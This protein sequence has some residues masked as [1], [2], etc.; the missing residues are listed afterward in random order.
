MTLPR[1]AAE[2]WLSEDPDPD[3]RAE[4]QQLLDAGP[5]AESWPTASP[6]PSSSVR[7]DC[8][9]PSGAGPNR[10]NRVVVIRAAAGLCAY[11]KANGLTDGPVLIGYDARHKSDVFAQDTA[12]VV[13]GAGLDAVLL[14][15]PTPTPVVAFGIRHL[16]GRRRSGRDGVAQ[17]AAGQRLQGLPGRRLADRAARGRGDRRRHRRGRTA[18]RGAARGRLADRPAT[19]CWTPT[20]TASPSWCPAD[21]PRDAERRLHAAARRRPPPGRGRGRAGGL[22]RTGGGGVAG[23][24]GSG[25]PDRVVPEPGGAGRDRRGARAGPLDGRRLAV[26]NDPD[27]DRCAVASTGR[28]GRGRLADAARGRAGRA[29]R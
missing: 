12:A 23:G 10:M 17:S 7:R 26:A 8:A 5:E 4:L 14:D 24:P 25:L 2:A 6:A 29:A 16:Q 13:R 21:A 20:W 1:R 22:R 15:R 27:A 19:T 11:L 3:T 28:V 18:G 9:A